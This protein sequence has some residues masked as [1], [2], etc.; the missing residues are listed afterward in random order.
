MTLRVLV[1]AE[2]L[3][4]RVALERS[5]GSSALDLAALVGLGEREE[6]AMLD[7]LARDR[8]VASRELLERH[9]LAR[10]QAAQQ[11]VVPHEDA[12]IDVVAGVDGGE[13]SGDGDADP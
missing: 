10:L 13:G 1:S 9:A 11:L 7:D 6:P 2:G 3:P 8:V 4:K 5:S 12:L